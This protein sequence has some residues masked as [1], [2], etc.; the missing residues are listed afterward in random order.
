MATVTPPL[1]LIFEAGPAAERPQFSAAEAEAIFQPIYARAD[2]LIGWLLALHLVVALVLAAYYDTY[3]AAALG[4]GAILGLFLLSR[5]LF[6]RSRTTRVVA[7]ICLQAFCAL[8]IWQMRGMAEQHFWFFTAATVM[9]LYQDWVSMWPG[10][11]LIIAQHLWFATAIRHGDTMDMFFEPSQVGVTKFVFHF[12]IALIEVLICSYWAY[13]LRWQTLRDAWQ[14]VRLDQSQ[15]AVAAQLR[16]TQDSES[17]LR[18]ASTELQEGSFRMRA[19][20]DNIPDGAWVKDR[21]GRYIAVNAAAA[22]AVGREMDDILGRCDRELFDPA[23]ALEFEESDRSVTESGVP[24]RIEQ[25]RVDGGG[26]ERDVETITT[27]IVDEDGQVVGTTGIAR[28]VTD[29]KRQEQHRRVLE[30]KMQESQKLESLGVLAGGIAHDFNNLLMGVLG[31]A[32]LARLELPPESPILECVEHIETAALRAAEL[33]KQMLAYSGKG[34][35]VVQHL[36]LSKVVQEM[37]HLLGTVV[38][39][40]ALVQL[41]LAEG[42]PPVEADATQIRQVVMNLITNASDALGERAGVL[43]LTTGKQLADRTYLA[44]T[45]FDDDLESG[46]YVYLEVS[47][48]GVGMAPEM[49]AKIFD[50]FF[51][52]KFTGRGL[53]LAA[54]LGIVRG[55]RGTIRLYSEPGR[56]TTFKILFPSAGEGQEA[57]KAEGDRHEAGPFPGGMV[58]VVDDEHTVRRVATR[59]LTRLGLEVITVSNG[60][61]ALE[62]LDAT[63]RPPK[64][65]ILDMMMPEMGGEDAFREIR[66]RYPALPVILSSGYNEQDATSRFVGRG[67]AGFIGKPYRLAELRATLERVL[68]T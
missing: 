55:H 9:I 11:L 29:R 30:T 41:S 13:L 49:Q 52:T 64:V 24:S 58:L 62:W 26:R 27:P 50:P 4:G 59:M 21:E 12:G 39:K 67:L 56:G 6:P 16:R 34:R 20:L 36:D 45:L 61:E 14:R 65:V 15:A 44:S 17:A 66:R 1:P 5:A 38:S 2:R 35:F 68:A 7:G 22:R 47:D 40:K 10:P 8:A 28:D 25:R 42:L 53:G 46:E 18:V 32:N 3:V 31:N 43:S 51:T 54:V 57:V 37:V 19:I 48:N 23:R 60:R 33:T 63:G